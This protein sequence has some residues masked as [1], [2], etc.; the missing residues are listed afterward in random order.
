M[1][2]SSLSFSEAVESALVGCSLVGVVWMASVPEGEEVCAV[3]VIV[4]AEKGSLA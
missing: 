4:V 2:C 3:V 1:P